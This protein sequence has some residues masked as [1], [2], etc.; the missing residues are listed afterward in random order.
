VLRIASDPHAEAFYLACGA[1]RV[2]AAAS[3]SI[4]GRELP[5][6]ELTCQPPTDVRPD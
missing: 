3:A 1:V 2:G 5:L 6:L 4:P